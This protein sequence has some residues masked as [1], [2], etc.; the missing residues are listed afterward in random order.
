MIR[1]NAGYA[2]GAGYVLF[3]L[4]FLFI[5]SFKQSRC[6]RFCFFGRIIYYHNMK[7]CSQKLTDSCEKEAGDPSGSPES[8]TRSLHK[9]HLLQLE[10]IVPVLVCGRRS[11][12]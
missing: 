7:H 11:Q 1:K 9:S 3:L 4:L 8:G 5:I 2:M 10:V 12:R 6:M